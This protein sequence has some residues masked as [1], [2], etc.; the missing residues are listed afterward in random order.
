MLN[1][2]NFQPAVDNAKETIKRKLSDAVDE[3]VSISP[4][5]VH[6]LQ[7]AKRP[8]PGDDKDV[9]EIGAVESPLVKGGE[10]TNDEDVVLLQ[11]EETDDTKFKAPELP[12]E[13]W[14]LLTLTV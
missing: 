6:P 11:E 8:A 4:E 1:K 12:K 9:Q 3:Q 14:R 5:P 10:K 7:A 2:W 13:V